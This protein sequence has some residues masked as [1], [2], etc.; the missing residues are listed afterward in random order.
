VGLKLLIEWLDDDTILASDVKTAH[1]SK[2]W[3]KISE[4]ETALES[5][6]TGA[7]VAQFDGQAEALT[8]EFYVLLS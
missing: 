2:V 1:K 3:N 7:V 5:E 6:I 8:N 4:I